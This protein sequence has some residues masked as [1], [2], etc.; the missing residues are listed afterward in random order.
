M[1][2]LD[3]KLMVTMVAAPLLYFLLL[4]EG[5]SWSAQA[6]AESLQVLATALGVSLVFA[7]L[8]WASGSISVSGIAAGVPIGTLVYFCLDWRG[9]LLLAFFVVLGS[10]CT[11]VGL[12]RKQAIHVAQERGGRRGARNVLANAVVPAVCALLAATSSRPEPFL[13]GFAGA[14]AAAAA[15]TVESEIGVLSRRRPR[16]I[17]TLEPV[18]AGVDGAISPLGTCS[19]L[20]ASLALALVGWSVGMLPA[21]AVPLVGFSGLAATLVESL[22]GATLERRGLLGNEGV[23]LVNTLTGALLAAGLAAQWGTQ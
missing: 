11:R 14:L 19:G 16:L 3:D 9:F 18:D 20:L 4:T 2:Q 7:L 13:W 21:G 17:T 6:T 10:L 15:D 1:Q 8:A 22:V 12:R 5:E 23:N